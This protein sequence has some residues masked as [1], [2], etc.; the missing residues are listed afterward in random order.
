M[1]ISIYFKNIETQMSEITVIIKK[2][3]L[4]LNTP[5]LLN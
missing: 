1:D 2:I 3:E 5:K 4:I